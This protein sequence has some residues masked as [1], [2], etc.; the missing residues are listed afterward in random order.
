MAHEERDQAVV[1]PVLPRQVEGE[2]VVTQ[3]FEEVVMP[4]TIENS[5]KEMALV[6]EIEKATEEFQ[7]RKLKVKPVPP[8]YKLQRQL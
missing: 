4:P 8:C 3:E 5:P 2:Q 7:R 1:P 6:P